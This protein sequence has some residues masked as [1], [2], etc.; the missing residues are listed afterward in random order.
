[1]VERRRENERERA[2]RAVR[3]GK[4]DE[5]TGR[6]KRSSLATGVCLREL[7]PPHFRR[8]VAAAVVA[9]VAA[10]AV[11]IVVVAVVV[12]AADRRGGRAVERLGR[13]N[14]N[15]ALGER[16]RAGCADEVEHRLAAVVR[17][18]R[19]ERLADG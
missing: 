15:G 17:L 11:V 6:T 10:V 1:M 5:S 19:P 4:Q 18:A 13:G 14:G 3:R 12:A 8:P 16:R 7:E 9:A 2:T